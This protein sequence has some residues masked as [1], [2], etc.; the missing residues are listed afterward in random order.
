MMAISAKNFFWKGI[1]VNAENTD[2]ENKNSWVC[3]DGDCT[4]CSNLARRFAPLLNRHGLTLVPLQ[5]PWVKARLAMSEVELLSEMR[6]LAAGGRIY[7][8]A[9]AFAQITRIIWWAKPIYWLSLFAPF[10]A[11]FRFGYR[12]V[13]RN[14]SCFGRRACRVAHKQR[15]KAV[16]F[17][18]IAGLLPTAL[19]LYFGRTLPG[20]VWMWLIATTL[21]LGAKAGTLLRYLNSGCR[22][23]QWRLLSYVFLWPGMDVRAFCGDTPVA[24]PFPREWAWAAAKTLCGTVLIWFGARVTEATHPLL[25]GWIGMT[26]IALMLHFGLFHLLSITW[27]TFGVNARP[28]MRSPL[29]ATSLTRFWGGS[30][31]AAFNDLV[32][33]NLFKP[34]AR[35]LPARVALFLVFLVSGLMHELVISVPAR[36]GYGL[37]TA[38]FILQAFGQLVE[39]S[40]LGRKLGI[41]AGYKGWCFMALVAGVPAI[42]LFNPIF[43]QRVILPMLHAIGPS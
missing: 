5:M 11:A 18:W 26:G 12:W 28:I 43:I 35:R 29:A 25:T 8:G 15:R 21:F 10:R 39:V 27:R 14:R 42:A 6:S 2:N 24:K 40:P 17:G 32:R 38:Y 13:A 37:P 3:F 33:E 34:L 4:L 36:G 41:G 23:T 1:S 31:N 9:D 7:G 22:A 30:W 20:W 19:A 16:A